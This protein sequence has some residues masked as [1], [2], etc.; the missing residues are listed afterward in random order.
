MRRREFITL[1]GGAAAW[2]LAARAQQPVPLIGYLA[3]GFGDNFSAPGL[4]AFRRG[5]KESG[6]VEGVDVIV[7]YRWAEGRYDRLPRLAADL[8]ARQVAMVAAL[9]GPAA[10]A[11]KST[12]ATTPIVFMSGSDPVSYGLVA[13]LNRPGGNATGVYFFTESLENKRMELLRDLFPNGHLLGVLL[14]PTLGRAVGSAEPQSMARQE[15]AR[16]LGFELRDIAASNEAELI[17]AFAD[18]AAQRVAALLVS[19]DPFF[20]NQ[21]E[22]II[23]LAARHAVPA[24]YGFREFPAAGGLMSYAPSLSEAV[25]LVGIYGG[26]I[27]KGEKPADLPVQQSTKI[28]L[29]INFKTAKSLGLEIPPTL[30]ALADEVIE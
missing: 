5:L 1:L 19:T 2:P 29:V 18:A 27:L 16:A 30:L 23:A 26:R 13:S 15:A 25:R 17:S 10:L 22:Q 12:T 14:N 24:L 9:S 28:E 21:R 3:T 11:A 7:E 4:A 8:V 20:L 6:Y